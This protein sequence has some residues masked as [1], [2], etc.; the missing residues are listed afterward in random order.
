MFPSLRAVDSR[1]VKKVINAVLAT[2]GS[3]PIDTSSESFRV[4]SSES[5]SEKDEDSNSTTSTS[6]NNSS[7]D[8]NEDSS[9]DDGNS[10]CSN[11]EKDDY[12]EG[13]Y[14]LGENCNADIVVPY[15]VC[16]ENWSCTIGGN[17]PKKDTNVN[18]DPGGDHHL[19]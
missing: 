15:V 8:S 2:F 14:D 18:P 7:R 3:S 13:E 11:G 10:S 4:S 16:P 5:E 6:K 9:D 1:L 12:D 19:G 17:D